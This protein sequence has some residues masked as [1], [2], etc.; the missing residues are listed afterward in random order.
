M[1]GIELIT[2]NIR[3]CRG[4]IV[5]TY[6]T[7][8]YQHMAVVGRI[9]APKDVHIFIPGTCECITLVQYGYMAK[10]ALQM[11]LRFLT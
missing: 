8:G 7:V 10:G 11:K 9:L 2:L 3:S 4:D 6:K 5:N 1:P